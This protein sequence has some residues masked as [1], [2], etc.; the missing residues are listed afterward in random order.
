VNLRTFIAIDLSPT[1][2]RALSAT[3]EEVQGHL[4]ARHLDSAL[5]L[6]PTKNLHL[7]LRFLG[8]TTP[9]QRQ[10]VTTAL[11]EVTAQCKPFRLDVDVSGRGLG[12]FPNLRQPRVL[13]SGVAGE[14]EALA[15][16]QARV[17]GVAQQVGFAAEEQKYSAHLTLAR[18]AREADRR[19]L[20]QAGQAIGEFAQFATQS[21]LISFQV[22][23]LTF[24]QS[25]LSPG[26]SR[27]TVLAVLPF[28]AV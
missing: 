7:T 25:E 3:Q 21:E 5:R 9:S 19:L 8:D 12:G 11:Q 27:Y 17:E 1:I 28:A 10:Q 13:W 16:L 14:F 6:S 23:H 26:G 20:S 4:R 2:L 24:Y 22:D 15:H 18:A